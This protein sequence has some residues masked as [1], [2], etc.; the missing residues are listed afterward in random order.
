MKEK[1]EKRIEHYRQRIAELET[2][3]FPG[4][5]TYLTALHF[6]KYELLQILH[7]IENEEQKECE[8]V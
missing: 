8:F 5:K 4:D 2:T 3:N 7:S 6:V 1:I